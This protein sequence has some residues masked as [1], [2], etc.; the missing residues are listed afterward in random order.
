MDKNIHSYTYNGREID[1]SIICKH[2]YKLQPLSAPR[3][4]RET[5]SS[6]WASTTS[7]LYIK[8]SSQ[9]KGNIGK[10]HQWFLQGQRDADSSMQEWGTIPL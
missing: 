4:N 2:I 10:E 9:D 6:T 5:E 7:I 8:A 1:I 3:R